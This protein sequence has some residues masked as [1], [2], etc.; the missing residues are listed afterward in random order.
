MFKGGVVETHVIGRSL[1]GKSSGI[2]VHTI[3]ILSL[4]INVAQGL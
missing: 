4:K 3:L 1:G 2:G